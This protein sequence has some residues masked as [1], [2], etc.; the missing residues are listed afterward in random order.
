MTN[1][2]CSLL[3]VRQAVKAIKRRLMW[4]MLHQLETVSKPLIDGDWIPK[5]ANLEM[6]RSEAVL[7]LHSL[8]NSADP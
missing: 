5:L 7:K 3:S 6:I 4:V 8:L 1:L 2:I